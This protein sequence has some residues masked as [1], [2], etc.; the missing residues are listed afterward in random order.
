MN[1]NSNGRQY[2]GRG[3]V[4]ETVGRPGQWSRYAA[5]NG[6]LRSF[7]GTRARV[8]ISVFAPHVATI[9]AHVADAEAHLALL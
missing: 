2:C 1:H 4:L 7:A 6:R 3:T 9:A 8:E 5:V